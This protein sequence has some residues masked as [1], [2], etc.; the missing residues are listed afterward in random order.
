MKP[1]LISL[2]FALPLAFAPT[3]RAVANGQFDP[4]SDILGLSISMTQSQA[5][6]LVAKNFPTGVM[7]ELPVIITTPDFQEHT[8]VGFESDVPEDGSKNI[9]PSWQDVNR[10]KVLFNPNSGT[11]DLLAIIRYIKYSPSDHLTKSS[12]V[13]ALVAKYGQP[14]ATYGWQSGGFDYLWAADAKS[15]DK[16]SCAAASNGLY[17]NYFY[18]DSIDNTFAINLFAQYTSNAFV[19]YINSLQYPFVMVPTRRLAESK[20]GV[21]LVVR[22]DVADGYITDL[23][24][25]EVNVTRASSELIRF[26]DQFLSQSNKL[27][28]KRM[29]SDSKNKPQL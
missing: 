19:S 12:L 26:R 16:R 20:C 9:P 17:A 22:A 6:E 24:E 2:L 8:V 4:S 29:Q 10:I 21:L 5:K 27:K 13:Q 14:T 18:E 15:F 1:H 3:E 23:T 25:K 28:A 11:N 7:T